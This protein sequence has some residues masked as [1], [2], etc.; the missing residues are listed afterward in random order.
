MAA[1]RNRTAGHNF[2]RQI[3][4]ELKSLGFEAVSTRSESRSKDNQGI[5]IITNTPVIYQPQCKVKASQ[6]NFHQL[7][8]ETEAD[9][10]FWKKVEKA[11]VKFLTKGEYVVMSKENFYKLI[12]NYGLQKQA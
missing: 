1:N 9:V 2:E 10:V 11:N 4:K 5:D 3:I 12:K 7:L 6:P 8:T